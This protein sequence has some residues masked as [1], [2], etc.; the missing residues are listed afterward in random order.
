MNFDNLFYPM[1]DQARKHPMATQTRLDSSVVGSVAAWQHLLNGCGYTPVL[2]ITGYMDEI[3]VRVTKQFQDDVGFNPTGEVDLKTWQ[4]G[5]KHKKLETWK[6]LPI[7][8]IETV[9]PIDVNS[10]IPKC[11]VD[12]I[13]KFEGYHKQLQDGTDRV[14]A[15]PDPSPTTGWDLPTIGYGTT[16]YP[17]GK[18]VQREDV[19]TRKQAEDY[20]QWEIEKK[21]R[22]ALEKIPTWKQMNNNQRGALYSFAYNLG[23]NFYGSS[24]FQSI[25]KVCDSPE[26]WRDKEF[27]TSQFMKYIFANGV[28]L[29]GLRN[30][31]AA[32]AKLFCT[33][34]G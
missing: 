24:D 30:R 10:S 22:V 3:T 31:R 14:K 15:Y 7:P 28:A 27:V 16:Y 33:A 8:P 13:K 26:K 17:N 20:L 23:S 5:L 1:P 32:E 18:Q 21:C 12:L 19:I 9:Q 34:V 25:T 2:R 6:E 11:A 29:E 4:A